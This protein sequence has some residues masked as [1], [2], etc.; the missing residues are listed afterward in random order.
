M[1][2]VVKFVK[3]NSP[4][5]LGV[6]GCIGVGLTSYLSGKAALKAQNVTEKK[7]KVKA[8]IPAV[9]S[10][11]A[12]IGCI[13]TGTV[14]SKRR[15]ASLLSAYALLANAYKQ[16]Q[17]NVKNIYGDD[18]H[19]E[20]LHTAAAHRPDILDTAPGEMRLFYDGY[21]NRY[22]ESTMEKVLY[23]EY[24]FNRKYTITGEIC[25]NDFYYFLG[26]DPIDFGDSLGWTIGRD[27]TWIDF[28]NKT[29]RIGDDRDGFDCCFIDIDESPNVKWYS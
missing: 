27:P 17:E 18:V 4:V 21:S 24:E 28:V 5:I 26:I 11:V 10:G 29:S 9:A 22:F 6:L 23:A 20:A 25:I 16:Y 7:E 14:I 15:E 12:T 13:M 19:R 8:Y 3:S 1:N 2:N